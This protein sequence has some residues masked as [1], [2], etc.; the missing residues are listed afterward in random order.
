MMQEIAASLLMEFEKWVL[1][2]ESFG[3]I[4]KTPLDYHAGFSSEEV[5]KAKKR[6]LECAQKTIGDYCLLA[7]SPVDAN[8]HYCTALELCRLT[9][10]YF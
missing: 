2:A 9:G 1:Q 10:D 4:L 5:I 7:G 3:T 8:A 6:R